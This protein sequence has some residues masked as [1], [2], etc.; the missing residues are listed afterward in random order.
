MISFI[1]AEE[2]DL[3]VRGGT[4]LHFLTIVGRKSRSLGY[5]KNDKKTTKNY[6][7]KV[8]WNTNEKKNPSKCTRRLP[9]FLVCTW[10]RSTGTP[11]RTRDTGSRHPCTVCSRTSAA[12]AFSPGPSTV[13]EPC[14]R[15]RPNWIAPKRDRGSS[16]LEMRSNNIQTT[17]DVI[18]TQTWRSSYYNT[19]N[20]H[21][22][23]V[24]YQPWRLYCRADR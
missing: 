23:D 14:P 6:S 1:R 8:V 9:Y 24:I 4:E 13:V 3:G 21:V 7:W 20:T 10:R 12:G 18:N 11:Y 15:V 22:Y 2:L 5:N 16:I 17:H 19:Y